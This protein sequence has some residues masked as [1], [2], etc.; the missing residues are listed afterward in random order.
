MAQFENANIATQHWTNNRRKY[1]FTTINPILLE[2]TSLYFAD[3]E[4]KSFLKTV[5]EM[6][7]KKVDA[8]QNYSKMIIGKK[9]CSSIDYLD[10][11][12]LVLIRKDI[13][14]R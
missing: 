8:V 1:N 4:K 14:S 12:D 5:L 2:P 3:S 7:F 6:L 11:I 9:R 10:N 13:K